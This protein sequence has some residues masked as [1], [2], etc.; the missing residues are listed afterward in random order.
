MKKGK[1]KE[2]GRMPCTYSHKHTFNEM[3]RKI[4]CFLGI[5][6]LNIRNN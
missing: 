2:L 5:P 4:V 3:N 1:V 6:Y